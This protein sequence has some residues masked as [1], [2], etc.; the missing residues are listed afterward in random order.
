VEELNREEKQFSKTLEKG[1]KEF[2]KLSAKILE[3]SPKKEISGKCAFNLYETYGFPLEMTIELARE[4][5]MT[6]H[7]NGFYK[8]QELHQQKSRA[9]AENKFKGGLGDTKD[10][11]VKLHTTAHLMVA[12]LR[13]V[14][15]EHI[16]QKG[17]NITPERL[18]FDFAHEEKMTEEQKTAV[19]KWVN[20]AIAADA[21]Q[22]LEEIPK[23]EAENDSTIIGAFW[24]KY[25]DTVKV[26]TFKD[27]TG[28]V[29]SRELCGGPHRER[30]G[31]LGTFKIKKEESSSRGVR[32][33][34]AVLTNL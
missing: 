7:E 27:D 5:G 1:E 28:K 8:A 31:D 32:R 11:T 34:K 24:E 6:V 33:I 13:E 12:A 19:E 9:G 4:Q 10:A 21:K 3:F 23:T 29:W 26:Y 30:T 16:S 18:R 14:L 15:G 17:S 20:A 2:E 22:T 25:P